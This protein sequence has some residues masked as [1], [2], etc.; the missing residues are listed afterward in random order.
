MAAELRAAAGWFPAARW[1]S[2]TRAE[3]STHRPA[4]PAPCRKAAAATRAALGVRFVHAAAGAL[5]ASASPRQVA[6][7]R[8]RA[9][10]AR[11]TSPKPA[12]QASPVAAAVSTT[13][14]RSS[15]PARPDPLPWQDL[16][17]DICQLP[18]PRASGTARRR[19][20]SPEHTGASHRRLNVRPRSRPPLD[21]K[22]PSSRRPAADPGPSSWGQLRRTPSE[23][24]LAAQAA[25]DGVGSS[26]G[27]QARQRARPRGDGGP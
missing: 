22:P 16:G 19:R 13:A 21:E 1:A 7:R 8:P 3:A 9:G 15:A 18:P 20:Q 4:R 24:G 26:E 12:C 27:D 14:S 11:P 5:P 17:A 2:C 6:P 25:P 10:T 23:S